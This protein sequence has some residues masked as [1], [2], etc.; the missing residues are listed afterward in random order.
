MVYEETKGDIGPFL[1]LY[2]LSKAA[3]MSLQQV[4]H[5]LKIANNNLPE[6]ELRYERLKKEIN[7]LEFKKQQSRIAMAY[8]NNQIEIKSKALTSYRISCIGERRKIEHLHN[9]QIRIENLVSIFKSN[10]EEYLKIKQTVEEKV[11]SVLTD[12]KLLLQ[13]ALASVI[14]ALRRNPETCN[15]V[16]YNISNNTTSASYG[17]NYLSLMS[18]GRKQ[19]QQPFAYISDDSY[20]A[21]ILEETEKLYNQ[22]TTELTNRIIAAAAS[23]KASSLPSP[24]A[25]TNKQKLDHKNDN[26]YQTEEFRYNNNQPEI[27]DNDQEQ[28]N[29]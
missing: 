9:E 29:E 11:K 22:L 24:S 16:L 21:L 20:T 10:N 23:I 17:S 4:V 1:N 14:E 15:S 28:S 26:T 25:N 8:F 6:I 18:P 19:Q 5:L 12:S 13:L 27:Y 2:R 7:R 3:G